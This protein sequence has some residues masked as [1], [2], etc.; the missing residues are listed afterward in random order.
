[1]MEL[2]DLYVAEVGKR[3]PMKG[4]ADIEAELRSTLEDMLEDQSSKAGRPADEAMTLELLK[5]YG[6]PEKVA[7]TYDPHPYLIGPRLYPFFVRVLKIVLTVLVTVLLI[8]LGIRLGAQAMSGPDLAKAISEGLLGI[9]AGAAQAFGNIA[10]VFAILERFAPA[11]EFKMDEEKKSWDPA[12]LRKAEKVETVKPW[13]TIASILFTIAALVLFNGYPELIGIHFLKDGA[14]ASIPA[15]T[16]A[17][18]RWMPYINV[19]WALQ[20]ALYLVVYRQGRWQ[21]A[22]QWASMVLDAAG[23]VIGY[24]LLSGPPIVAI[25]A[26][27]LQSAGG[28]DA[29]TAVT[30]SGLLGRAARLVIVIVMITQGVDLV[31][32]IVR[33]VLHRR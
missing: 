4:R 15:L 30:L 2:I 18:F 17:F 25:S 26:Q 7:A 10:L 19:L 12:S 32:D 29:A 11:S 28:L 21:S 1:M 24:L 23:L 22:T 13:E 16:E 14:W 3:L 27:A 33:K 6:S 20:L 5:E 9:I 31:K 8:T